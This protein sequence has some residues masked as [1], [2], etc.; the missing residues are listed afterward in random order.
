MKRFIFLTHVCAAVLL[1]TNVTAYACEGYNKLESAEVKEYRDKLIEKDADPLDRLFAFEQLVCA[2]KPTIRSYAI[3]EG[4]KAAND[5]LV[6]H[7]VMFQAMM[8]KTRLDVELA[9]KGDLKKE[10]KEFVTS[11]DGVFSQK[12]TYR[13]HKKG[14]I[15][16]YYD[17]DECMSSYSITIDGDKVVY[18]FG[19]IRGLFKLTSQNELVGYIKR[20]QESGKIPAV[21]KLY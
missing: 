8:Q 9:P 2:S 3:R 11:V 7:E 10:D 18:N 13:D 15:T 5:P 6:R 14:C 19:D 4:L 20:K 17:R 12:A 1:A 16:L 21:I